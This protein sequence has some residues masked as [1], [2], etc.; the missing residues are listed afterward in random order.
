[1][2]HWPMS[3][4]KT[5]RPDGV[6]LPDGDLDHGRTEDVAGVPEADRNAP[7]ELRRDVVIDLV[8]ERHGRLHVLDRVER[9]DRVVDR[10]VL[11]LVAALLVG[12][13]LLLD[14][15]GVH[16]RDRQDVGR[17]V[18]G[19]DGPREAVPDD[20]GD[21]PRVVQMGVREQDEIEVLRGTGRD[22]Q[23]LWRKDRSWYRP[24]STRSFRPPASRK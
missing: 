19:Q 4:E 1:M 16:E 9:D 23:F 11:L 8:D 17:R 15:G 21:E 7:P 5:S 24:Q 10:P 2:F 13:V 6:P 22:S 12:R 18:R 3:P 20:L 14:L